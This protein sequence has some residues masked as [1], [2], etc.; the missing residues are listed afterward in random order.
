MS[1]MS[2]HDRKKLFLNDVALMSISTRDSL[3]GQSDWSLELFLIQPIL[4][5]T[6][7]ETQD[8]INHFEITQLLGVKLLKNL[9][10]INI[11]QTVY[12]AK[13]PILSTY[14]CMRVKVTK[15]LISS[16]L[17]HH[18][19]RQASF[20]LFFLLIL[21]GQIISFSGRTLYRQKS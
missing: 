4:E 3:V 1:I 9:K 2:F 16:G 18:Y 14:H 21:N 6:P 10:K 12:S 7:D 17:W 11:K 8:Y 5:M 15:E 19:P 13:C 20:F